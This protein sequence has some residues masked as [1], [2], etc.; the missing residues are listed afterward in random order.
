ML[1]NI[2]ISVVVPI[3][4]VAD[5]VGKCIESLLNQNH[6]NLQIILVDD[7]S[8]DNSGAICDDFAAK[9]NRIEV[10]HKVNGGLVDAR[11]A[12]LKIAKGQFI[13]FVDGDDWIEANM[14]E[15]MLEN[16]IQTGADLVHTGYIQDRPANIRYIDCNFDTK[17]VDKPNTMKLWQYLNGI[18][19]YPILH[20]GLWSKLFKRELILFC[21]ENVPNNRNFGED[22]IA[23]TECFLKCNRVSLLKKAYYHYV[24]RDGAFTSVHNANRIIWIANMFEQVKNL[25]QK[26]K[27]YEE[28]ESCFNSIFIKY[29]L[30]EITY[31]E[32]C[33]DKVNMYKY[34][35]IEELKDKKIIIYGAGMLGY[36]YYRQLCA[37]SSIKIV[38]WI[39]KNFE[40]FKYEEREVHSVDNL[41]LLDYDL[42]LIAV[43]KKNKAE[44]IIEE[45]TNKGIDRDKL[46]WHAPIF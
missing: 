14:Y 28:M 9:D 4:N 33:K 1:D 21:Y 3:Y 20:P 8:T 5:Y 35:N 34:H 41:E 17:I 45:L 32:R 23:S 6:R 36:M 26:Y 19:D 12:G 38:D 39:D 25:L 29:I 44:Q 27:V 40:S 11:K 43:V 2:L 37:Y 42:I 18:S 10:I 13:G 30:E 31:N 7:G 24:V 46:L 15:E 16:I 22:R